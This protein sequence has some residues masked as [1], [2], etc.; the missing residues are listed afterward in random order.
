MSSGFWLVQKRDSEGSVR[1][2]EAWQ[3][4][5]ADASGDKA[6]IQVTHNALESNTLLLPYYCGAASVIRKDKLC[7]CITFAGISPNYSTCSPDLRTCPDGYCDAIESKNIS[8]CPQDC[9]SERN[10]SFYCVFF[11]WPVAFNII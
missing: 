1:R 4:Q 7:H 3:P 8:I 9:S 2:L 5:Q 6:E 10:L 11:L